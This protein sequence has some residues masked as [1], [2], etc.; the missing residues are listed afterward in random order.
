[1]FRKIFFLL[2]FLIFFI[3]PVYS[4]NFNINCGYADTEYNQCCFIPTA[5]I[6]NN[7]LIQQV[8]QTLIQQ[9]Q[10]GAQNMI[11]NTPLGYFIGRQCII[12]EPTNE[13]GQCICKQV[14]QPTLV[15]NYEFVCKRF[16]R[17]NTKF[18]NSCLNCI[19]SGG[20]YSAIGCVPINLSNFVSQFLLGRMIGLAGI[21][22][23]F[24]IIYSAFQIQ[25]SQGNTE[26][27]KKSQDILISCILG[28]ILI[29]FSIFILRLI[30]VNI[31]Q[32]PGLK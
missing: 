10:E 6:N 21:I 22:A 13:N 2:V 32:I 19:R 1:M 25:S 28:L 3:K 4:L 29:I 20:Y 11:T 26:K 24:C 14:A 15:V 23:L 9:A 27:I 12:G 31:L 18:L 17:N 30:G 7:N 16:F 8:G 5:Q